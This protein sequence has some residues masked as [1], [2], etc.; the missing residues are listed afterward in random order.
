MAPKEFHDLSELQLN[1]NP[2]SGQVESSWGNLGLWSIQENPTSL[3]YPQACRQ[4]ACEVANM[5][6][7]KGDH[8]L[9]DTGFGCGDQLAVWLQEFKVN[10]LAGI[11][12]SVSQTQHAQK[13]V[14]ALKLHE[15]ITCDLQ[16]G[17]SCQP[18]NWQGLDKNF[19]RIIAL[20][21]IYHFAN[22]Q[23]YFSLCKQHLADS[24]ALVVSDLLLQSDKLNV[25]QQLVLKTICYVSHIPF[26]NLKTIDKYQA[27]L[28]SMGLVMSMSRDISEQVFLPFGQWLDEYIAK[29]NNNEKLTGKFSWLKYRGTAKFLRWGYEKNIFSY[30]ILRIEHLPLKP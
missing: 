10:N 21:C 8:K 6:D 29:L 16:T 1:I 18:S 24:G 5:A 26:K 25:W 12:L 19:D 9:L 23:Q 14:A 20:D 15:N 2:Q 11:N 7:L 3:N 17:D 30:H 4:L 27:E 28:T 22:K 13:K